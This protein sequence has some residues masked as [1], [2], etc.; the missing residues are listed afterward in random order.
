MSH[1]SMHKYLVD[2]RLW[3][4]LSFLL[5]GWYL[6]PLFTGTLYVPVYDN[7]DSNVVWYKILAHSGKIFAPNSSIIPDM[8]HGLPRFT[9]GSEFNL[10]LWLYRFFTPKTAYIV[11][12]LLIH[13]LAFFSMFIFL[14]KYVVPSKELY[15]NVPVFVGSLYFSLLPFWSGSGASIALLPLVTYVLLDIKNGTSRS[16]EWIFLALLPLYS[17]FV[18]IYFF[19]IVMAGVYLLYDTVRNRTINRNFLMALLLMT[20]S[21]LLVEY[22]LVYSMLIDSGFISHRTEFNVFFRENLWETYRLSLVKFLQGHPPH[23]D[24]LQ[25]PYLLPVVLMALFFQIFKRRYDTKE[26]LL[27]W[28]AILLSFVSGIWDTLLI[29]KFTLPG[30]TL[31]TLIAFMRAQGKS[32]IFPGILLLV[33]FLSFFS[34]AFEYKGFAAVAE[35]FPIFKS[36]NMIRFIFVEPFLY[37]ILLAWSVVVFFEKLKFTSL[38]LLVFLAFQTLYAFDRSFY[39]SGYQEGYASFEQYYAPKAF[40]K[41]RHRSPVLW[42]P[43][44]HVIC[45]GF[46]PAVA[47]YNGL[48]TID[49]YSV[50]YPLEYKHRFLKVFS[51]YQIPPVLKRWGSKL[52]ITTVPN[53][54]D[55]YKMTKGVVVKNPRFS[56]Q[57][58]C[59]LDTDY[60][61]SAFKLAHPEMKNLTFVSRIKNPDKGSW[62]LY[63][64][65]LNCKDRRQSDRHP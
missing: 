65:K 41:L 32:R 39:K 3:A 54:F 27:L 55:T 25:Q 22:R 1:N 59:D 47:L 45:Y 14:K 56:V 60:L 24:P 23:A 34:S 20:A 4:G 21:F 49:G 42:K 29:N 52:Y 46:E 13:I 9:Y 19:Y 28:A 30:V 64:Y 36:F 51:G 5:L 31:L 17:S 43:D 7:L 40:G 63:V 44:T 33:I 15:G 10:Q 58:L 50:N 11:N 12:E 61:I 48:H 26:S 18:L 53:T 2:D 57:A 37:A 16:W 35:H 8:M 6:S 38:A 62:D